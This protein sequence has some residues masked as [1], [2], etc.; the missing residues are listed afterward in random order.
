MSDS[1]IHQAYGQPLP[2]GQKPEPK[3]EARNDGLALSA[4][5]FGWFWPLGLILGHSSNRSA[6]RANRRRSILAIIG[7][8]EAYS[9]LLITI[10]L[11]A[12]VAATAP[13]SHAA[14]ASPSVSAPAVHPSQAAPLAPETPAPAPATTAPASPAPAPAISASKAQALDSAKSYLSDGQGFSRS[15]LIKQLSS[16]YGEK[17]SVA[18]ATW[19]VDHSGADWKAQAVL[20]AKG[21][22]SDGSGFS[23]QGLIDQLT[24][25]Y[26]EGFTQA[27]AT[28][29]AGQVGL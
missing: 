25:Q 14:P 23:R 12:G 20:S 1:T 8:I 29:A 10:G 28:Y 2:E 27:Q 11:I 19:A 13:P 21:Y 6:K 4:F 18:D 24:S 26:G 3:G 16:A 17:F 9:V 7:L 15:G 22:V 5:L